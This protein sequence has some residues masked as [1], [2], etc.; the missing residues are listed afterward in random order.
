M[1]KNNS[2][3]KLPVRHLPNKNAETSAEP[4]MEFP[5]LE[6][7]DFEALRSCDPSTGHLLKYDVETGAMDSSSIRI[8]NEKGLLQ[9][10]LSHGLIFSGGKL[11][12]K[13]LR[14]SKELANRET[15]THNDPSVKIIFPNRGAPRDDTSVT[16]SINRYKAQG[17]D[18]SL[19]T[20][21]SPQ[22]YEAEH[23][24]MLKTC[25]LYPSSGKPPRSIL[26]TSVG[27]GDGKSFVAA[28]LAI[29]IAQNLSSPVLLIDC[30]LR[31]P[32][33]HR[34]FG[35]GNVPGLTEYLLETMAFQSLLQETNVERLYILPAG[36]TPKN[37]TEL[38]SSVRM[39][40][41]MKELTLRYR[42]LLVLLD[43]PPSTITAEPAVLAKL[44]S[45][46]L[47]VVKYGK[48]RRS[49]LQMVTDKFG[50]EKF[51]GSVINCYE[52]SL[53]EYYEYRKYPGYAAKPEVET[54]LAPEV[55]PAPDLSGANLFLET[56]FVK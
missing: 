48:T 27:Q 20:L 44:V 39:A 7:E 51:I 46:I 6:P 54:A 24:R 26:I 10:L 35:F 15:K 32:S 43:S 52:H 28:N 11:T 21:L 40:S 29:S 8:L 55:G 53:R 18:E 45:G 14:L 3:Q 12:S 23:F 5:G 13:G 31:K 42:D 17:L 30:D 56:P 19:I 37:P 2:E 4:G 36:S 34:L 16:A 47:I 9:R 25:I 50:K 41:L 49:D 33:I 1:L 38:L 22:S